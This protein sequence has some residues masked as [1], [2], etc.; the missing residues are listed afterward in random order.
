LLDGDK[1]VNQYF[2]VEIKKEIDKKTGEEKIV[3]KYSTPNFLDCIE[4]LAKGLPIHD[5]EP[6]STYIVLSPGDLVYVPEEGKSI[7]QINWDDKKSIA[8]RV[9]IMKSS[10]DYQAHFLPVEISALI[11]SYD[12]KT[13]RGEFESMN[14]SEKTKDGKQTI[15]EKFIKLKVDRLGNIKP[16]NNMALPSE[17]NV[18]II[19]LSEAKNKIE[20]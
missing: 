8:D 6:N 18:S 4:R 9:Y 16:L 2:L 3:R 20:E 1:G 14:K 19:D 12:A 5:E 7:S 17:P 15:K 11:Q 13:K 10:Q